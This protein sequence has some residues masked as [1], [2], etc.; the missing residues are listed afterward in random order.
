VSED[1]TTREILSGLAIATTVRRLAY[2]ILESCREDKP[3]F[4]GIY[5]RGVTLANRVAAVLAKEGHDFEIGTLDISLYR[6]D[7]DNLGASMPKL[8][9]SDVPFTLEGTR[10]ILFDEV[11]FTGRTIRAALDGLM[12]YGR[13]SKI[14]LAVLADR[15]HRELPIQPDYVGVRVETERSDYVKVRFQEDDGKEGVFKITKLN[16][17]PDL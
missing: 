5:T 15:G 10:V 17:E 4:V 9:S 12:D 1:I 11:I 7:L 13:P 8:E 16:S 2:E 3:V 14:E 6:D